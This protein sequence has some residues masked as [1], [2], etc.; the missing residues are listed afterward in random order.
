MLGV[1]ADIRAKHGSVVGYAE[2]VGVSADQITTMRAHL[3]D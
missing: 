2:S 1:L 3:L